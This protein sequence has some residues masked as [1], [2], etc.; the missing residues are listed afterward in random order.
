MTNSN[1]ERPSEFELIAELFAPL[2]TSP[3]AFGLTDDVALLVPPAG[4][5]VV[6]KA[7]AVVEGVHFRAEDPADRVAKKALRVNLS[8]LAAKGAEA[9]GYLLTLNLPD[10]MSMTWLADFVRGL[11]EDQKVYGISL[12]GGDTTSTP[13][14]LSIAIS[15]IGTIP[16]GTL[17]RRSG[18][19]PGDLVFVSGTIGDAAAGLAVL[20]GGHPGLPELEKEMLVQR[21]QL[22]EP[23]LALGQALRGVASASL[24]VSDGLIGDLGHIAD[25]SKVRIAIDALRIPRSDALKAAG[26]TQKYIVL[27]ATSG[28]DY[29]IAFTAPASKREQ[30]LDTASRTSTRVTE[31][32]R[33]MQGAGVMLLGAKGEEIP[34]AR[35]GY[36]HF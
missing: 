3:G 29:E 2:A 10:R 24:D 1:S 27:A 35:G 28:D 14:P 21:Y 12:F 20:K 7:D 4:H 15:A 22:P 6:L 31:I 19:K 32:G 33:V 18:A 17:T 11:S 8:D 34:V 25:V 36:Q 26:D 30:V 13:G 5:E 16:T 23:R 9:L